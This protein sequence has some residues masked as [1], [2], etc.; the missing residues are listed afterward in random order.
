MGLTRKWSVESKDFEMLV[1]D[2]DISLL[3][4]ERSRGL[5]RSI[6]LGSSEAVWLLHIFEKLI[7]VKDSMY[8]GRERLKSILV[9]EGKNQKGWS[10]LESE[11]QIAIRFFQPFLLALGNDAMKKKM[12]FTKVLQSTMWLIEDLFWS[13]IETIARVP[14]WL[15]GGNV[16][17]MKHSKIFAPMCS[18]PRAPVKVLGKEKDE[19]VL[20]E[21]TETQ[22]YAAELSVILSPVQIVPPMKLALAKSGLL[23]SSP[24][25]HTKAAACGCDVPGGKHFT[26]RGYMEFGGYEYCGFCASGLPG[27][28]LAKSSVLEGAGVQPNVSLGKTSVMG[29]RPKSYFRHNKK[30]R[31]VKVKRLQM[32]WANKV[33]DPGALSSTAGTPTILV[34][35]MEFYTWGSSK[36]HRWGWGKVSEEPLVVFVASPTVYVV[37]PVVSMAP[38]TVFVAQLVSAGVASGAI[39]GSEGSAPRLGFYS[40]SIPLGVCEQAIGIVEFVSLR[41]GLDVGLLEEMEG[42]EAFSNQYGGV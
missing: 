13:S 6:R 3:I 23:R 12:C 5:L 2:S 39:F 22:S 27:F 1:K 9:P 14:K 33:G 17:K 10:K 7:I 24:L 19:G 28:W 18:C 29:A 20:L 26:D 25:S 34:W 11:L 35:W 4:Q 36:R 40:N 42:R 16:E 30:N 41:A 37:S 31:P 8:D 21:V 15:S 38:L 32:G